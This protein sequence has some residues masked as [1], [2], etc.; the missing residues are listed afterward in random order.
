[1]NSTTTPEQVVTDFLQALEA[2]DHDKIAA[3]LAPD[4]QYTNVSL[5]TMMGGQRVANLFE[6]L[7]RK[8]TGFSVK[9]HGLA[10]NGDTVMTERTDILRVGTLHVAFWV[11]GT[12][13]V[14]N[15]QIVLWRDYF[16][17]LDISRGTVRGIIGIVL[18]KFRVGLF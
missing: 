13:Q 9:M 15:G 4:L 14:Q 7:L 8:G 17:W 6:L 5:P 1:M 2:K 10:S 12:F 18:P 16:D 3:L 11:C